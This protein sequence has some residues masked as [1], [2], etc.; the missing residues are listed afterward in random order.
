M[1]RD[2]LLRGGAVPRITTVG[3]RLR[4]VRDYRGPGCCSVAGES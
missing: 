4:T 1:G 2:D 3:R